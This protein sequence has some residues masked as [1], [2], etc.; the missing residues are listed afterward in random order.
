M[1]LAIR[2]YEKIILH[3]MKELDKAL[4]RQQKAIEDELEAARSIWKRTIFPPKSRFSRRAERTMR[5]PNRRSTHG[6]VGPKNSAR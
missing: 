2:S 6:V 1:D 4:Y 3:V 5:Q